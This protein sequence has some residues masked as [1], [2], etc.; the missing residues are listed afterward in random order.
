VRQE[1]ELIKIKEWLEIAHP[2]FNLYSF[3]LL[4]LQQIVHK[5]VQR[6][7]CVDL[8]DGRGDG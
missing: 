2:F 1:A 6:C 3:C 5:D 4:T 8:A 7:L